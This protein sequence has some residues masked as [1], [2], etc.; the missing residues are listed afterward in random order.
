MHLHCKGRVLILAVPPCL[1]QPVS[2]D[3][4]SDGNGITGP[5]WGHSE[6]VFGCFRIRC[7][8]QMHLSLYL[9][10]AYSSR[11]RVGFIRYNDMIV[12]RSFCASTTAF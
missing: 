10:A 6:V 8:Q 5:D 3:H 7:F 9:S 11:Q 2:Y 4:L 1:P 12:K